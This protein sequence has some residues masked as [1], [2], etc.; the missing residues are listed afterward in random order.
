M[1]DPQYYN[2]FTIAYIEAL[3]VHLHIQADSQGKAAFVPERVE[4]QDIEALKQALDALWFK[5]IQSVDLLKN[6]VDSEIQSCLFG[7]VDDLDLALR[8]GFLISDRVVLLDYLYERILSKKKPGQID[9]QH[10]GVIAS[11]LCNALVLAKKGRLVIMPHPFSWFPEVK[12]L[13]A[14]VS[15][16][17]LID[18]TSMSLLSTLAISRT[19][20]LLPYTIAE[21]SQIYEQITGE[22]LDVLSTT[23][24]TTGNI[25][26]RSILGALL[27]EKLITETTFHVLDRVPLPLFAEVIASNRTFYPRFIERITLGGLPYSDININTLSENLQKDIIDND[28]RLIKELNTQFGAISGMVSAAITVASVANPLTAAIKAL[29]AALGFGAGLSNLSKFDLSEEKV[30]VAVFRAIYQ[31]VR[32]L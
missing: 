24:S 4:L 9:L 29:S 7:L 11:G 3:S 18:P 27:A 14:E 8:T 31:H 12:E 26:F 2:E 15:E 17:A 6:R 19:C 32:P 1:S 21:S 30:I 16:K 28:K 5:S 22:S 20:S 25:A 23:P 13:I 10:L